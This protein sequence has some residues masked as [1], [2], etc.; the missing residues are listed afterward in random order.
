MIIKLFIGKFTIRKIKWSISPSTK[1]AVPSS[2]EWGNNWGC[3]FKKNC[4][5]SSFSTKRTGYNLS[6]LECEKFQKITIYL[7]RKKIFFGRYLMPFFPFPFSKQMMCP[8]LQS[9][10]LE[11]KVWV[12]LDP[13]VTW[14]PFG[15]DFW[16]IVTWTPFPLTM[17]VTW[18]MIWAEGNKKISFQQL[19][20]C[21]FVNKLA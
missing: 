19:L 2:N 17:F 15:L 4:S 16:I 10:S 11:L 5:T 3:K 12:C 1:D 7:G 9:K 21:T 14:S 6:Y 18:N 8:K 20:N 13:H